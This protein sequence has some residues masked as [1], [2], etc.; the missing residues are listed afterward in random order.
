M[1]EIL[2]EKTIALEDASQ[3]TATGPSTTRDFRIVA[4]RKL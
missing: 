4:I 3:A 1:T 2:S